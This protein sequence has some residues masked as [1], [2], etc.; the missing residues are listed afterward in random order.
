MRMF[1]NRML[2]GIFVHKEEKGETRGRRKFI[3]RS[4]MACNPR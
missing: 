3:R 4:F 1:E 2:R